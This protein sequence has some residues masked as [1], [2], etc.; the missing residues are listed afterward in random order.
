MYFAG[1][2]SAQGHLNLFTCKSNGYT[3][4]STRCCV[5]SGPAA[6]FFHTKAGEMDSEWFLFPNVTH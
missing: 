3:V 1:V 6:L 5:F 2:Q 4:P